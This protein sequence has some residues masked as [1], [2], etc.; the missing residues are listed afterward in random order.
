MIDWWFGWH[1]VRTERYKL[2]HPQ[3]NFFAQP[4][5]DLSD[6]PGLTD[7]ERYIDN[8]SWVDEYIGPIPSRLAITFH[9]P[10]DIGLDQSAL[11]LA[12]YGTMVCALVTDS[13]QGN[14]LA[15][16]VH[17]VRATPWGSE[18]RSRFIFP[19]GAPDFIGP[20]MLDHLLDRDDSSCQL[21]PEVIRARDCQ[22]TAWTDSCA[23]RVVHHA[24]A[25]YRKDAEED[26]QKSRPGCCPGRETF[27]ANA[28]R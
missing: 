25:T 12:G 16:L 21:P 4:R 2:W 26:G 27:K 17:A 28:W 19:P 14:Q 23:W 7:R 8:T 24:M 15:R 9:D 1:L 13:D 20:P 22:R 11:K 5:L 10:S 3:A 18:M 6:V